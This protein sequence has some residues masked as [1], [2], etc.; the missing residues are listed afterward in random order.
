MT[1]IS[2]VFS[3]VDEVVYAADQTEYNP[4]PSVKY[5]TNPNGP[6]TS[7]WRPTEAERLAIADG[8]DL[9]LT[10]YTFHQPLQPIL[11]QVFAKGY[12]EDTLRSQGLIP[13]KAEDPIP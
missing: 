12:E 9:Y 10:L 2:P 6:V 1:P 4:L 5:H 7:R 13:P 11:L 8:S 3:G